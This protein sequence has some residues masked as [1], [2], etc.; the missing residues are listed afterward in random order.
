MNQAICR[1]LCAALAAALLL[2]LTACTADGPSS[3]APT[4]P[5][6]PQWEEETTAPVNRSD[7][8]IE[9]AREENFSYTDSVGNVYDVTYRIPEITLFSTDAMNVN[10]EIAAEYEQDFVQAENCMKDLSS[11]SCDSLDYTYTRR[12]SVLSVLITRVYFSHVITYS[13]YN[14]DVHAE[15][16]LTNAEFI[17]AIGSDMDTVR[18][19]LKAALDKDYQSK[20]QRTDDYEK[21]RERTLESANLNNAS[22]FLDQS[23]RLCAICTEYASVGAEHFDVIVMI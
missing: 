17:S 10:A 20:F 6:V 21:N 15:R 2:P 12:E 19:K 7:D 22:F 9:T 3:D 1:A 11:L 23:G 5:T 18:E 4:V 13:V 16:R 14:L 8:F